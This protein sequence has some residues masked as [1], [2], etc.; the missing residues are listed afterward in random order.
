MKL[1]IINLIP[2]NWEIKKISK[3]KIEIFYIN[4]SRGNSPKKIILK[5]EIELDE[6]F[7]EGIA[8]YIG[9]G[10]LSNDLNHLSF[11]TI[12]EDMLKFMLNFFNKY[13][14]ISPKKM[15]ITLKQKKNQ[16]SNFKLKKI[17]KS[18]YEKI[19][20]KLNE[21]TKNDSIEFQISSVILRFIF[22]EIVEYIINNIKK[23][24]RTLRKAF[25]RG[26]FAAE[27]SINIS[28]NYL[29]YLGFHLSLKKEKK[30]ALII[31]NLLKQENI[32]SKLFFKKEKNEILIQITN[33]KNYSKCWEIELFNL[34][35]RKK[36]KFFTKIKTTKFTCK[37]KKRFFQELISNK[38][39]SQRELSLMI[40]IHPS[41]I[42][43]IKNNNKN[44][45]NLEF[46]IILCK[47]TN[48][49]LIKLKK[50]IIEFRVNNITKINDLKF[51][52][53]VI[54]VKNIYGIN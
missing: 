15:F 13:F 8:M 45:I 44:F 23:F 31:Q 38:Y 22:K 35:L 28:N 1:S 48:I 32:K 16:K 47:I 46:L 36:Y 37:V 4:Q 34:N 2:K 26:L 24:P 42:S 33:W 12:D 17:F 30:L 9:D 51:I 20:K 49:P 7:I 21:R 50:N 18:N 11:T 6:Q 53:Y 3:E 52:D 5:K 43:E 41:T 10:K 25:L 39:L 27:G 54:N 19:S 29:V 14:E 40:G